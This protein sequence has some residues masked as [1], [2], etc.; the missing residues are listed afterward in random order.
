[1]GLP[2]RY[3]RTGFLGTYQSHTQLP[4][5]NE[6]N[7]QPRSHEGVVR[8]DNGGGILPIQRSQELSYGENGQRPNFFFG[9]RLAR[10]SGTVVSSSDDTHPLMR[11]RVHRLIGSR[12][13]SEESAGQPPSS[14]DGDRTELNQRQQSIIEDVNRITRSLQ[15]RQRQRERRLLL[16]RSLLNGQRAAEGPSYIG[17]GTQYLNR[18]SQLRDSMR[19]GALGGFNADASPVLGGP[20]RNE[21]LSGSSNSRNRTRR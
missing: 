8:P 5:L 10:Q 21:I 2:P 6:V 15:S 18:F 14:D 17:R 3:Q 16:R 13:N 9:E 19:P 11:A 7:E 12:S 20:F 4:T 1:M